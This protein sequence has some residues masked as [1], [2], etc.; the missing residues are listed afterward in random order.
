[1]TGHAMNVDSG[2]VAD[3]RHYIIPGGMPGEG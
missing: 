3:G 2:A 1:M